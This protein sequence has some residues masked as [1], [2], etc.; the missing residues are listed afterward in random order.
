MVGG[1]AGD[2]IYFGN[3]PDFLFGK[4][5]GRQIDFP[6]EIIAPSV[7]FAALGCS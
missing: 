4:P 5:Y 2:D 7:S 6:F 3:F 1:A